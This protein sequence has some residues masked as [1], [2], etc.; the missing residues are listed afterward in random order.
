[1]WEADGFV[2]QPLAERLMGATNYFVRVRLLKV[3][4][5]D[6]EYATAQHVRMSKTKG[7]TAFEFK[8]RFGPKQ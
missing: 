8:A 2:N 5:K 1:M 6:P 3:G 7:N 4:A